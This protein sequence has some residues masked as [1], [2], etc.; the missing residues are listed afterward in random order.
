MR[1]TSRRWRPT[2]S[3]TIYIQHKGAEKEAFDKADEERKEKAGREAAE[4]AR[5]VCII[6]GRWNGVNVS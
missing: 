5:K 4:A 3:S 6:W 2:P 1:F